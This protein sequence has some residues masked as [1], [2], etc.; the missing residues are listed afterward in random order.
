MSFWKEDINIIDKLYRLENIGYKGK[1]LL[2]TLI[3]DDWGPTP[4]SVIFEGIYKNKDYKKS[5]RYE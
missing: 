3:T 1:S 5:I 2:D 4:T